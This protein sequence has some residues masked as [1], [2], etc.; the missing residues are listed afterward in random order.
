MTISDLLQDRGS[1]CDRRGT[2]TTWK[3]VASRQVNQSVLSSPFLTNE[4]WD[5]KTTG[6][7]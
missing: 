1:P 2:I 3:S 6:Q 5:R 7:L 4:E